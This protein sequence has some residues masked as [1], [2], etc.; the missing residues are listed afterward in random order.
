MRAELAMSRSAISDRMLRDLSH[1]ERADVLRRIQMLTAS[2]LQVSQRIRAVRQWSVR[3]LAVCCLVLIPWTVGLAVS[4]PRHYV[5][6]NWRIAWTGFDIVLLGCLAITAW[7]LWK[8]RQIVVPASLITS[9]LLLC[10]AWFD[11][12]T[13]NGYRDLIVSAASALFAEL[14]LATMLI[15]ISIRV[16]LVGS[17]AA[18]ALEQGA[19]ALIAM[20]HPADHIPRP[21]KDP[22][23][24]P[25]NRAGAGRPRRYPV[26]FCS[27][28]LPSL[29]PASGRLRGG[30]GRLRRLGPAAACRHGPRPCRCGSA[31]PW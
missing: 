10:D 6:G 15:F 5:V 24:P 20:A 22:V 27:A 23:K 1:L 4:L 31:M 2:E 12:L 25:E 28:F 17:R 29:C 16:L 21:A 19:P 3:F 7:G 30:S 9:V 14:P 13:A 11:V 8:R 18:R 26:T